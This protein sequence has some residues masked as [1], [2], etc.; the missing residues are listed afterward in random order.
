LPFPDGRFS[1]VVCCFALGYVQDPLYTLRELL[2]VLAPR[3]ILLI[4]T[5]TPDTDLSMMYRAHSQDRELLRYLGRL[6]QAIR[7][8][9]IHSFD[10][11]DLARLLRLCGAVRPRI[12]STFAGN[13]CIGLVEKPNSSG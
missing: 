8:G 13:A 7:E 2:R 12:Y 3:G 9:R 1:R 10:P 11:N 5:W 4:T 6:R